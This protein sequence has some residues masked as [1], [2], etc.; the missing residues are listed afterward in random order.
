MKD[1][2]YI[3]LKPYHGYGITKVYETEPD[4][5][6][7]PGTERYIV[8]DGEEYIGEEYPTLKHAHCAVHDFL[9]R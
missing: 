5:K 8:D 7:I 2:E 9:Q 4:G 1:F 6:R 3:E